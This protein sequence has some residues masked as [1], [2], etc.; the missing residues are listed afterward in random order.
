MAFLK[1]LVLKV[2]SMMIGL[3]LVHLG[4]IAHSLNQSS[5]VKRLLDGLNQQLTYGLN[6][7]QSIGQNT[8]FVCYR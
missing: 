1:D 8:N 4:S 3:I 6:N 7:E 5:L 2:Q